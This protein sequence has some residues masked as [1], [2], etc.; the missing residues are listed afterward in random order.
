MRTKPKNLARVE[1]DRLLNEALEQTF[2][3]SDPIALQQIGIIGREGK[4]VP[5][6]EHADKKTDA[7]ACQSPAFVSGHAVESPIGDQPKDE[8][9]QRADDSVSPRQHAHSVRM[10][11]WHE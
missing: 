3:A 10:R 2:P 5:A 1:Q 8:C 7:T 4:T 6:D 11:M 9:E